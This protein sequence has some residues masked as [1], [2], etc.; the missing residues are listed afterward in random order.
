MHTVHVDLGKTGA[1]QADRHEA[2]V[3]AEGD[4]L[5][6]QIG[7]ETEMPV[8]SEVKRAEQIGLEV[9]FAGV[10]VVLD[11]VVYLGQLRPDVYGGLEVGRRGI[12][13]VRHI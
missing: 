13:E 5:G 4:G 12:F 7:E 2:H 6:Q 11:L 8:V 9:V 1:V 3:A 10:G